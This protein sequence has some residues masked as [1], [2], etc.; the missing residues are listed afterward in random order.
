MS[1]W[2]CSACS[3][4]YSV[5][6]P[7]C[8]HCGGIDYL[9][10]AMPKITAVGG[11]SYAGHVD[12]SPDGA[13]PEWV[14]ADPQDELTELVPVDEAEDAPAPARPALNASTSDWA[15]YAAAL[16]H[17]SGFADGLTRAELIEL[18]DTSATAAHAGHA[19]GTGAAG[20]TA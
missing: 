7:A 4:A 14:E 1:L 13:E 17:D 15:D 12:T 3:T 6:A 5:G 10:D 11:P 2:F 18:V 20:D 16:G 19:A 9:E 8:P